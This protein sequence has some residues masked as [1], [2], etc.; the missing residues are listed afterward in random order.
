MHDVFALCSAKH[1]KNRVDSGAPWRE[2]KG[3]EEKAQEHTQEHSRANNYDRHA[4]K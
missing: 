3:R 4:N 1:S 2:N